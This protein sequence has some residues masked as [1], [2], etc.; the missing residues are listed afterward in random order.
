[1]KPECC[2]PPRAERGLR[3]L[4]LIVACIA[5]LG[6]I[7]CRPT[8]NAPAAP[9]VPSAPQATSSAPAP[10]PAPAPVD[11]TQ[12]G[13]GAGQLNVDGGNSVIAKAMG[14]GFEEKCREQIR[15]VRAAIETN[16]GDDGKF[17]DSLTSISEVQKIN[18]CPTSHQPYTYNPETGEVHCTFKGHEK[19]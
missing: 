13:T 11:R 16:R 14:K 2:R 6:L 10:T 8:T 1:M 4:V 19:L 3:A 18:T 17:P 5:V 12:T 15:Q 7:G 9:S